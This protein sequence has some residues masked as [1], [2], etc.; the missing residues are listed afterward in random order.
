MTR[1]RRC[2][3][4]H[5]RRLARGTNVSSEDALGQQRTPTIRPRR[6]SVQPAARADERPTI[7]MV[8]RGRDR[9][10]QSPPLDRE[11]TTPMPLH[12]L[13]RQVAASV[14]AGPK[15]AT[16]HDRWPSGEAATVYGA[17][18]ATCETR[19]LM[20]RGLPSY[21]RGYASTVTLTRLRLS[22]SSSA[23]GV[24]L[25]GLMV[26]AHR[27]KSPLARREPAASHRLMCRRRSAS[28]TG[29]PQH[30]PSRAA[31]PVLARVR[32]WLGR[33]LPAQTVRH[34]VIPRAGGLRLEPARQ[35]GF[36]RVRRE[37]LGL[38]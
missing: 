34:H 31:R 14:G 27:L 28:L 1:P 19:G 7:S 17:F 35:F 4:L 8:D 2:P 15:A 11:T 38:E 29:G 18:V 9:G 10:K 21:G 32:C 26:V 12:R 36:Q 20:T 3:L 6:L 24:S 37:V 33:R 25:Q 16:S 30:T 5:H 23:F 13:A 22:A